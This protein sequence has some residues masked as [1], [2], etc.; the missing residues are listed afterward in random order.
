MPKAIRAVLAG[1]ALF[2]APSIWLHLSTPMVSPA[3]ATPADAAL[4]FG[5]V[6]RAGAITP[7]HQER[8]DAGIALY[9]SG[10]AARL[11]VSNTAAAAEVM[12]SYLLSQGIPAEAIERDPQAER[13]PD[14]CAFEAGQGTGRSVILVSQRFHLPR[15]ALHCRRYALDPQYVIADSHSRAPSPLA[16]KVR[17]RTGRFLRETFLIWG[18]LLRI[19]PHKP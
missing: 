2:F 19:Y 11:V 4:I 1:V 15:L 17:V 18:T 7:L 13:S 14:T 16:T 5:A 9:H 12:H 6:V 8:L 10:A 3:K